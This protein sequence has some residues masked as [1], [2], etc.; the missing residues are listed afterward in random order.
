MQPSP[1]IFIIVFA[2]LLQLGIWPSFSGMGDQTEK[3]DKELR[4]MV[5][6]D[7]IDVAAIITMF[8]AITGRT[9][10]AEEVEQLQ[11]EWQDPPEGT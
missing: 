7:D 2:F 11:A 8:E 9:A 6:G 1:I 5:R 3:A 10:T 4:C